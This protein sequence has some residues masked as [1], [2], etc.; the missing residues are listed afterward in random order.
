M[1]LENPVNIRCLKHGNFRIYG[2]DGRIKLD[3]CSARSHMTRL[4]WL[5]NKEKLRRQWE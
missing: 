1:V 4:P 3:H 5:K 2:H